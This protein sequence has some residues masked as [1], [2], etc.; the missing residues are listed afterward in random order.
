MNCIFMKKYNRKKIIL[1]NKRSNFLKLYY[2]LE[3][4][5]NN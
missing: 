4:K 1:E 3:I 5:K 2:L